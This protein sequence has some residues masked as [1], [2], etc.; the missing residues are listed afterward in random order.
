MKDSFSA[1]DE[2][3]VLAESSAALCLTPGIYLR[4][5]GPARL[6][7]E[8]L[9]ISKDGDETGDAMKSRLAA[10]RLGEGRIHASLP[11]SG[12]APSELKI[13][14]ELGMIVARAD[15]LFSVVLNR[16]SLRVVCLR[17]EVSWNHA[18]AF[19]ASIQAGYYCERKLSDLE[20]T[21]VLP[22]SEDAAAQAEVS[23]T[24]DSAQSVGELEAA[25]R[26]ALAPWRKP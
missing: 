10:V 17:G 7:I 18:P 19:S 21:D 13:D 9:R 16:E 25:L 6:Q 11:R 22:A 5:F 24:L 15:A 4:C 26:N 23:A 12:T 20:A 1:G 2:I 14:T 8:D 3:R